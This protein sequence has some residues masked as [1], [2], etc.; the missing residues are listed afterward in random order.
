VIGVIITS[1]IVIPAAV[2]SVIM[3][4]ALAGLVIELLEA[5]DKISKRS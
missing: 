4:S 2:L 3:I 1:L 5:L